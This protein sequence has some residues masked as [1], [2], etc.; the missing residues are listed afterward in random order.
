MI[1][2]KNEIKD[3]TVD[4]PAYNEQSTPEP[5][6]V[7]RPETVPLLD[8]S[9]PSR[10]RNIAFPKIACG[11]IIIVTILLC[12][13]AVHSTAQQ[14]LA[15][16]KANRIGI[17]AVK[18]AH[19]QAA[20]VERS[21]QAR[22][23]RVDELKLNAKSNAVMR[24]IVESFIRG[25]RTDDEAIIMIQWPERHSPPSQCHDAQRDASD[26][27]P[28]LI[29]DILFGETNRSRWLHVSNGINSSPPSYSNNVAIHVA[30]YTG[31]VMVSTSPLPDATYI[32]ETL[33]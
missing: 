27:V 4:P 6:P 23:A 29:A 32:E 12:V 31:P 18:D 21:I 14:R 3:K 15:V 22:V 10:Q 2:D 17:E 8:L 11:L 19:D 33:V 13:A 20:A 5:E 25:D 24:T 9:R 16:Q 28:V 26:L 30:S 7:T 1:G